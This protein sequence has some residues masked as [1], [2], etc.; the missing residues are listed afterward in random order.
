MIEDAD[1]L[2]EST[3]DGEYVCGMHME[4]FRWDA[5]A[6]NL[7]E[8]APRVLFEPCPVMHF[9]PVLAKDVKK[10]GMHEAPLYKTLTRVGI[11]NTTGHSTNYICS[12]SLPTN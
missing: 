10:E 11:L 8:S 7:A 12:I 9:I 6:Q 5:E 2:T 3:E 1:N 4:G